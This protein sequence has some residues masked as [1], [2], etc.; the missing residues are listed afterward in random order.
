[1]PSAEFE[2]SLEV[3]QSP[4]E[5]WDVLIDVERIAGW[6]SVVGEVK[7]LEQLKSYE[8]V[9]V[10][11][12]G[13]FKLKADLDI[14]VTDLDEGTSIAFR[15]KGEDRQV[16][17]SIIVD[18]ALALAGTDSGTTIHVKGKWNVIGTVATMGSGTIRKKADHIMEEFFTAA[19]AEFN[20]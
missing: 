12:F 16:S 1:M 6:V 18:G 4:A 7:E 11:Q 19:E 9:L 13:P 3:R 8:A 5:C 14:Q 20:G 10:D 15:A 2:Q 17:T